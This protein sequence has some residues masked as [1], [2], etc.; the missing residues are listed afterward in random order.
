VQD[1]NW[2]TW[3]VVAAAVVGM[4]F[5][6]IKRLP[7]QQTGLWDVENLRLNNTTTPYSVRRAQTRRDRKAQH[8]APSKVAALKD[9]VT[10]EQLEAF[11][12]KNSPQETSF[13]HAQKDGETKTAAA[14]KKKKDDDEWEE[15]VD[16][17]TGKKIRRKK[18]KKQATQNVRKEEV[19]QVE[20]KDPPKKEDHSV[21]AAAEEAIATGIVT[22]PPPERPD[23][24]FSSLEEWVR[25]LISG[26]PDANETKRFIDMYLKHLVSA[27]IFYKVT[28]MMLEDSRPEMKRLGVMC[29]GLTPSTMSFQVLAQVVQKERSDSTVRGD[30]ERYL[31]RYTDLANIGIIEGILRS[32]SQNYSTVVAAQKLEAAALRYLNRDRNS[33]ARQPTQA[34]LTAS[35]NYFR[36]FVA[37]LESL[38]RSSNTSIKDQAGQTLRSLEALLAPTQTS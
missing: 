25:R 7:D 4:T 32:P 31:I 17:K 9:Q 18:K 27:E 23:E 14:T 33:A 38:A 37:I 16:P 3:A 22:P 8:P 19:R 24:A 36:R 29:A 10:R 34:A 21:D 6:A 13:D 11:I 1:T 26:R 12:R 28:E 20:Q 5:E 2:K 35:A 15:V 30:A